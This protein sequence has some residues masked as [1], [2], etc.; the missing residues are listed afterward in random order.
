MTKKLKDVLGYLRDK[1]IISKPPYEDKIKV[2]YRPAIYLLM[3]RHNYTK[4]QA[5]NN[6]YEIACLY[7]L[8][9]SEDKFKDLM[10]K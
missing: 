1:L 2:L 8:D 4:E 10:N 6:T 9:M 3:D 7:N 5:I